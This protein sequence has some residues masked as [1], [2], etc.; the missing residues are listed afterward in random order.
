MKRSRETAIEISRCEIN[1][2]NVANAILNNKHL[3]RRQTTGN[4]IHYR[5][6][7]GVF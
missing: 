2:N 5:Y 1:A 6:V 3:E 4:A 7:H